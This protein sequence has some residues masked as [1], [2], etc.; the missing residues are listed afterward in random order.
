MSFV[1]SM[2]GGSVNGAFAAGAAG[3]LCT[4]IWWISG[5][6]RSDSAPRRSIGWLATGLLAVLYL[7]WVYLA[8]A[9]GTL[10]AWTV[11]GWLWFL[12]GLTTLAAGATAFRPV[13]WWYV[14]AVL[15][16]GMWIAAVLSGWLREEQLVRCE[17]FFSLRP[18]VQ[19]VVKNPQLESC[20]PA[21]IRASGRFPRT[22]W[23]APD[24]QRILFTTQGPQV[25]GAISGSVCTT[26]LDASGT[27]DCIGPPQGKSQGIIDLPEHERI[28]V[29]QWGI[30][31]PRGSRGAAI[32]EVPRDGKLEVLAEHWFD[33][34]IGEGF[35]EPR[36][37]TLYMYSD[38]TNGV[39]PARFPGFELL[40]MI[41]SGLT[42][43][44]LHYDRGRGEGVACGYGIGTAIRGAPYSERRFIL[45]NRSPLDRLSL[46]WGC[47]WDSV[48]GKVYSTIPN[49]GLLYR[50]DY[51]S[52]LIEKRWFVGL[53]MRSVAYDKRRRRVYFSN[54]LRGEV[55][56]FD[57]ASERVVD[58]WFVGRFSRWV[59]LT[60]D[61]NSIL[62]TGNLGIVRIP[63][64]G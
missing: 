33:E 53:G 32:F 61:G 47:D 45:A 54:F 34:M 3:I 64:N 50:I 23:Q 62:A 48:A 24:G 42:P 19:L 41:E 49:L 35:Y 40:P 37:S 2:W 13:P 17:D 22:I 58:R 8:V 25:D 43:G 10:L 60:P 55:L 38:R 46:T 59:R 36:N 29:M 12:V 11:P 27:I 28:L 21:E 6:R 31:T 57:E 15:P 1:S 5:M 14:P 63:L 56:A 18:P 39:H 9:F 30:E 7:F 44:E 16:L 4:A 26:T 20:Q 51:D 52:G